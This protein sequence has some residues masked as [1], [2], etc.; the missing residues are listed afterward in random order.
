MGRTVEGNT[1]FNRTQLLASNPVKHINLPL[2]F[3]AVNVSALERSAA[4]GQNVTRNLDPVIL[5]R[6]HPGPLRLQRLVAVISAT[7]NSQDDLGAVAKVHGVNS[8]FANLDRLDRRALQRPAGFD[9]R[10]QALQRGIHQF[11]SPSPIR[12]PGC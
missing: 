1:S 12:S 9:E 6:L 7:V 11:S 4:G 2:T 8:I 10:D 5:E 3:K